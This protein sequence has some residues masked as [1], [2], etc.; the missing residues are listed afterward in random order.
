MSAAAREPLLRRRRSYRSFAGLYLLA[1]LLGAAVVA[2][3]LV[4]A[5]PGPL[6]VLAGALPPLAAWG[7][8]W[9][10]RIGEEYRV[11]EESVEVEAG[12]LTRRIGNVQLFRVRDLG[13]HQS[14]LGRLLGVGDV[15]VASTDQ[16]TPRLVIR[17]VEDPRTVYETLRELVARSQATRRTMIVED[18]LPGR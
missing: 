17:G 12:I 5:P 16:S 18:D 7:W 1:V 11:F 6:A 8:S 15:L 9:L 2:G 13:L 4:L 10:V 3:G 14:V